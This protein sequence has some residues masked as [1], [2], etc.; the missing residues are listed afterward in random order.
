[1]AG[2]Y[3]LVLPRSLSVVHRKAELPQHIPIGTDQLNEIR[4]DSG[5]RTSRAP[6][7]VINPGEVIKREC[8]QHTHTPVTADFADGKRFTVRHQLV[9]RAISYCLVIVN[10]GAIGVEE[11]LLVP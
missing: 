8:Y 9:L 4:N 5:V 10:A 2:Q 7:R 6:S 3:G 11:N 1:M